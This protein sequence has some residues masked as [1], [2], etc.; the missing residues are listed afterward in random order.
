V[1]S[2]IELLLAEQDVLRRAAV[3]GR[4][5]CWVVPSA[6]QRIWYLTE[7]SRRESGYSFFIAGDLLLAQSLT[8]EK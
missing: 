3:F 2:I 8:W 6:A 7:L 1:K 5:F 4:S